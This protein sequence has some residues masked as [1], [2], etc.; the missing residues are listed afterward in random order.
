MQPEIEAIR[1]SLVALDALDDDMKD[2]LAN[3]ESALG[4]IDLHPASGRVREVVTETVGA[5]AGEGDAGGGIAGKW[6]ELKDHLVHWEEEHPRLV[7]VIGR[8]SN[9]LAALGL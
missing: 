2:A 1:R 7:L 4:E 3:L 6:A 5:L 9:S 8:L